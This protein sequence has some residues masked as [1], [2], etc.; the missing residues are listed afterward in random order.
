V[1]GSGFFVPAEEQLSE[2]NCEDGGNFVCGML[3]M[4]SFHGVRLVPEG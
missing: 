3:E 1:E 2:Q 4:T